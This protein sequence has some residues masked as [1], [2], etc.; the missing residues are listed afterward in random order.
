M[1]QKLVSVDNRFRLSWTQSISV[2]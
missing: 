1:P 2:Y